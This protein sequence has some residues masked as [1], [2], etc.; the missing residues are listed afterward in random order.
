MPDYLV[1]KY[2]FETAYASVFRKHWNPPPFSVF[3]KLSHTASS[4]CSLSAT[5]NSALKSPA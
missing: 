1:N 3:P 4:A 5:G 2:G